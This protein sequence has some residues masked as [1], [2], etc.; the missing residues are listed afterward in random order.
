MQSL[1]RQVVESMAKTLSES[2]FFK[3]A[4]KIP[5]LIEDRKDIV[6]EIANAM[7]SI[8]AFCLINFES[9]GDSDADTPG[10][11][12][13]D[14]S[15]N[16]VVSE[17]PSVWRSKQ[18]L[19]PS[20]TEIGEAVARLLH[21]HQPLDPDG[22]AISGGVL[23]FQSMKQQVN[24]SMMQQLVTFAFPINFPITTPSR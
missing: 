7:E 13:G 21:H 20:A 18:G 1:I 24:D 8:G 10:P 4:P 9:S 16:V 15:F 22:V 11:S 14:C 5:A 19:T 6:R 2:D 23:I 17:I 12:L 3:T